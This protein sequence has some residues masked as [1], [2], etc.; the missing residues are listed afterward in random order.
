METASDHESITIKYNK[1]YKEMI[2]KLPKGTARD[3]LSHTHSKLGIFIDE[4][5]CELLKLRSYFPHIY[6]K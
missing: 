6:E 2:D 1:L 5:M 4:A 3:N